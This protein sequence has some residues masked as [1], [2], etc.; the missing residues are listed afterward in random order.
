MKSLM[1][2]AFV[3]VL[4]T[5]CL[6]AEQNGTDTELK[7][8][9]EKAPLFGLCAESQGKLWENG[10]VVLDQMLPSFFALYD[11]NYHDGIPQFITT[12]CALY[13]SHVA[14]SAS[15]RALELGYMSPTL[16]GFLRRLWPLGHKLTSRRSPMT[17][18]PLGKRYWPGYTWLASSW[19]TIFPS[20]PYWKTKPIRSGRN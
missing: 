8:L 15:I 20:R 13:L 14:V 19:V 11:A 9:F 10:V 16:H 3:L 6:M 7:T 1:F 18:K 4:P 17:R 5:V 2:I 12:D